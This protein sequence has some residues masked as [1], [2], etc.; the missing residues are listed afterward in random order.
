VK[1]KNQAASL[2]EALSYS[3]PLSSILYFILHSLSAQVVLSQYI[4]PKFG[5]GT[6]PSFNW[7]IC[8]NYGR[9]GQELVILHTIFV[10]V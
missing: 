5:F 1:H 6:I 4:H 10:F 2:I 8:Q 9:F 7:G 3:M